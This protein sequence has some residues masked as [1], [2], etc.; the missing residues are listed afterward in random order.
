MRGLTRRPW[1]A[2]CTALLL[3]AA[4]PAIADDSRDT[5]PG[6]SWQQLSPEQQRVLGQ[7]RGRWD[8]LPPGQRQSLMRG[9]ER[10]ESMT[11]EQRERVKQRTERWQNMTPDEQQRRAGGQPR[12]ARKSPHQPAPFGASRSRV[13]SQA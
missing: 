12:P 4:A 5:Q 7:F 9:A 10:W 11:P 2:A 6:V 8:Q 3:A 13:A 1:L